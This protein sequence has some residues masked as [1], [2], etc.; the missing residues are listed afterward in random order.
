MSRRTL[1]E[2]DTGDIMRLLPQD[3]DQSDVSALSSS[4]EFLPDPDLTSC[5]RDD[6][7]EGEGRMDVAEEVDQPCDIGQPEA[8]STS[9]PKRKLQ[10]TYRWRKK[11]FEPPSDVQF[12]GVLPQIDAD[13]DPMSYFK[14]FVTDDMLEMVASETNRYSVEKMDEVLTPRQKKS[15]KSWA[16]ISSWG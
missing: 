12:T 8:G 4:D 5:L 13:D 9:D 1:R 7:S 16:C 10:R 15:S 14:R 6:S 3:G 2:L 11:A